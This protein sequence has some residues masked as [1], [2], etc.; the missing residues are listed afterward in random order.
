MNRK[1]DNKCALC[2]LMNICVFGIFLV[3]S[4]KGKKNNSGTLMPH[5]ADHSKESKIVYEVKHKNGIWKQYYPNGKARAVC[6][7]N[8]G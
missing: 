5:L 4:C 2:I 1:V 8:D 7:Y 6:Y 3:G